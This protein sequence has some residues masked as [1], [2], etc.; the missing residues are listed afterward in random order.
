MNEFPQVPR[1]LYAPAS[2][3]DID[4]RVLGKRQE[5]DWVLHG[6]YATY[7]GTCSTTE[8][9]LLYDPS[10]HVVCMV[11]DVAKAIGR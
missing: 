9:W 1:R 2:S 11:Y 5:K 8:R 4:M 3:A 6:L 7:H 10:M